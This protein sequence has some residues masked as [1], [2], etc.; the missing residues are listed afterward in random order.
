M[1][2]YKIL[3]WITF[4]IV[5]AIGI[6]LIFFLKGESNKCVSE[7][8]KYG[9]ELIN[10]N[11]HADFTCSCNS[12]SPLVS[13]FILS[14]NGIKTY[15]PESGLFDNTNSSNRLTSSLNLSKNWLK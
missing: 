14:K 12:G 6:Y 9:I 5:I 8:L 15:D 4:I 10:K 3:N 11:N 13:N 1:N 2:L 7:P